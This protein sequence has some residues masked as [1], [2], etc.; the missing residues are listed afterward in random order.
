M[1]SGS[2]GWPERARPVH[3][4]SALFSLFTVL[5]ERFVS[6]ESVSVMYSE[7]HHDTLHGDLMCFYYIHLL[8]LLLS[9]AYF[10]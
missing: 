5:G 10:H 8:S 2:Q 4:Q 9:P 7:I 3:A 1:G 6:C